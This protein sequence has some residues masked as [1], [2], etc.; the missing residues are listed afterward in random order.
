MKRTELWFDKGA[1][2]RKEMLEDMYQYPKSALNSY[3]STYG[4]GILYGLSYAQ[5]GGGKHVI[6][7]GALKFQ[8]EIYLQE[9]PLCVEAC[10]EEIYQNTALTDQKYHIFFMQTAQPQEEPSRSVTVLEPVF[11]QSSGFSHAKEHGFYYAYV[12]MDGRLGMQMIEDVHS[13]YGMYAGSGRYG[14]RLPLAELERLVLPVLEQKQHRHSMDYE[15]LKGIYAK[16]SIQTELVVLYIQEYFDFIGAKTD[17]CAGKPRQLLLQLAEA[18]AHLQSQALGSK[19]SEQPPQ[20]QTEEGST[21]I[22]RQGTL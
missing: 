20:A 13:L 19:G 15:L 22:R 16:E 8:G 12:R 1:V 10:F 4:D 2:L 21:R 5:A 3:Y 9:Q 6:L 7:P 14:Y 11:V 18:A 17:V